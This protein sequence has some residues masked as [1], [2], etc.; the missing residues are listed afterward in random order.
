M[1]TNRQDFCLEIGRQAITSTKSPTFA[2]LL[3]SWACSV[4]LRLMILPYLGCGLEKLL[5]TLI[6]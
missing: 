1:R 5:V 2:S 4:V 6:V 3:A